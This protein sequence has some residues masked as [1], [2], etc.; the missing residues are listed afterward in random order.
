MCNESKEVSKKFRLSARKLL[1][2]YPRTRI[3]REEVLEQL[4]LKLNIKEYLIVQ[5]NHTEVEGTFVSL[6]ETFVSEGTVSE[7]TGT[8]SVDNENPCIRE[9]IHVYIGLFSKLSIKNE[10]ALDLLDPI[11]GKSIHGKYESVKNRSCVINYLK[12]SDKNYLSSLSEDTEKDFNLKLTNLA[13]KEGVKGAMK[14]FIKEK[15][16]KMG[17]SYA[18]VLRN[19]KSY[20]NAI[21]ME[22][23][24]EESRFGV[25]NFVFPEEVKDWINH[26][27][28][29][30]T[31]VLTG[32]S[33]WGKTEGMVSLL[34][35]KGYNILMTSDL[36]GLNDLTS[37]H[38]ALI[39]DDLIWC[40]IPKNY[41]YLIKIVA[42]E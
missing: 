13:E 25:E 21:N 22:L 42:K 35:S 8:L 10:K 18:S 12:K 24:K 36:N 6:G 26:E 39:L 19:V 40:Q 31:L 28:D 32:D 20:C 29:D 23:S 7:T 1:L 37:D 4:K 9:H 2:T 17:S 14:F 5:E 30:L 41:I 15:P 27:K 38:T 33:G 3:S 16:E 34:N 11:T